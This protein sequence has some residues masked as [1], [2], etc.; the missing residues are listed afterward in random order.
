MEYPKLGV[1]IVTYN[2]LDLLKE[3]IEHVNNQTVKFDYVIIVNNN[4]S[5]GTKEYLEE[6]IKCNNKIDVLNLET[7]E[8]GAGGFYTGIKLAEEKEMDYLLLIDDD[9]I[10]DYNYN[11]LI[12][13]EI[14]NDKKCQAFSGTVK[15]NNQIDV[16]HR[17]RLEKNNSFET[18][19][20]DTSEYKENTF[21]YSITTFCGLYI[22]MNVIRKI[23][24]P[25]KDFFI[26]YDDTEYSLRICKYT[27]I[28]NVN[29]AIINHKVKIGGI[30]PKVSWKNYYGRRNQLFIL[31]KYYG[32]LETYR[33][34]MWLIMAIIKHSLV[35][36]FTK[37]E[38][39]RYNIMLNKD[40]LIDGLRLNLGKN[41]KYLP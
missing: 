13:T 21:K 19:P 10:I 6:L 35:Y 23:G 11:E 3:N 38:N 31:N 12:V 29:K 26:W 2:R 16:V 7:N 40:A 33:F 1:V 15:V 14:L 25:L 22:S 9:A 4:S 8:G 30:Q 32:K 39:V 18:V 24:L 36:L 20:V 41:S 17:K 5:D 34:C 27:Y 37:D 28:K